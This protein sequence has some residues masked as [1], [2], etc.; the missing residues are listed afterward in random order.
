MNVTGCQILDARYSL[1]DIEK[2][3]FDCMDG[4]LYEVIE[5]LVPDTGCSISDSGCKNWS[6]ITT[7]LILNNYGFPKLKMHNSR[8]KSSN[9]DN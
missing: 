6:V 4:W 7:S 3:V 9:T 5:N 1:L 8:N 2:L